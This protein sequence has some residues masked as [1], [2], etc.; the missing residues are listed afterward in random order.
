MSKFD[1]LNIL[2][3]SPK[4]IS[5]VGGRAEYTKVFTELLLIILKSLEKT[6]QVSDDKSRLMK[7]RVSP[8]EEIPCRCSKFHS[9]VMPGLMS[10]P[11]ARLPLQPAPDEPPPS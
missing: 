7:M 2:R 6:P 11:K 3:P 9:T 8:Y 10:S 1:P 4:G 5:Q